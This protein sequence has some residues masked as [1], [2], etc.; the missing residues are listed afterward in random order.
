LDDS[1]YFYGVLKE[2]MGLRYQCH[3]TGP[4]NARAS[5]SLGAQSAP[6]SAGPFRV[7]HYKRL[8]CVPSPRSWHVRILS[9]INQ[10]L[11]PKP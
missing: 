5:K 3:G 2:P 7:G 4:R 6:S 11:L 10:I 9:V 8:F 1:L